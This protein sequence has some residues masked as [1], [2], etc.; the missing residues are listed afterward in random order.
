MK[1]MEK[2]SDL[3][4]LRGILFGKIVD[5]IFLKAGPRGFCLLAP[6]CAGRSLET[7]TSLRASIPHAMCEGTLLWS[8]RQTLAL[9]ALFVAVTKERGFPN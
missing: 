9:R 2:K 4:T 8:H 7:K 1:N 3:V 6:A 5:S